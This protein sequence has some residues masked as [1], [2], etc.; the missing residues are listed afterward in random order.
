ME[1]INSFIS[2]VNY[3][4]GRMLQEYNSFDEKDQTKWANVSMQLSEFVQEVKTDERL[5]KIIGA[6]VVSDLHKAYMTGKFKIFLHEINMH[7]MTMFDEDDYGKIRKALGRAYYAAMRCNKVN[8]QAD[9]SS[10]EAE[11]I[12][13][14][15]PWLISLYLV[16][17][18][19]F[20]PIVSYMVS[21]NHDE[22]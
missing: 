12:F 13:M 1:I 18:N 19:Y 4:V 11:L 2:E 10:E 21:V 17:M 14:N 22:T 20:T 7:L 5:P 8:G 15:N 3:V 6:S 9:I 16:R